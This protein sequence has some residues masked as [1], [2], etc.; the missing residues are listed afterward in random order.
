VKIVLP[1]TTFIKSFYPTYYHEFELLQLCGQMKSIIFD[2]LV[3]KVAEHEKSFGNKLAPST[4]EIMY[5]DQNDNI[6]PH[7]S[8]TG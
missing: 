5:L 6:K 1:L 8:S 2:K 3:E 7:D 4:D